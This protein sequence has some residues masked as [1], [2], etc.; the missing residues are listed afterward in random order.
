[1]CCEIIAGPHEKYITT[2]SKGRGT[3][4][5]LN[6]LCFRC[7]GVLEKGPH[8]F[9][10]TRHFEMDTELPKIMMSALQV[11]AKEQTASYCLLWNNQKEALQW[12]HTHKF[13]WTSDANKKFNPLSSMILLRP[14]RT[15]N[16][17]KTEIASTSSTNQLTQ[18]F[19][20]FDN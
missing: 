18:G 10:L 11:S 6:F 9:K 16:S 1:M 4:G 8:L 5:L 17:C 19:R 13:P 3:F 20:L 15:T 7:G 14:K 2:Q 12:R